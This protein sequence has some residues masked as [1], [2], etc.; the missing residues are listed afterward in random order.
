MIGTFVSHTKKNMT[1]SGLSITPITEISS[2]SEL[3]CLFITFFITVGE[4][5]FEFMMSLICAMYSN[6]L[7]MIGTVTAQRMYVTY[8]NQ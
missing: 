6:T 3:F 5:V 1:I 8:V 7:L 2:R 4:T